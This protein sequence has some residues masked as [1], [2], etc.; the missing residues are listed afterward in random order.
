M[1]EETVLSNLERY[2]ASSKSKKSLII[3]DVVETVKPRSRTI[4]PTGREAKFV[5]FEKEKQAWCEIGEEAV[6]RKIGK[7]F[8]QM[9]AERSSENRARD[10]SHSLET[11]DDEPRSQGCAQSLNSQEQPRHFP[12]HSA[13]AKSFSTTMSIDVAAD[14]PTTSLAHSL[15]AISGICLAISRSDPTMVVQSTSP[16]RG[17]S[18]RPAATDSGNRC[19]LPDLVPP[20]ALKST[21]ASEVL[22]EQVKFL[23]QEKDSDVVMTTDGNAVDSDFAAIFGD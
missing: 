4:D 1:L 3:T 9:T 6:R 11:P 13:S 12:T 15:P 17:S 23:P 14:K 5:R 7:A 21:P 10:Y 19:L 2:W 18:G 22:S 8:R 16:K 20:P